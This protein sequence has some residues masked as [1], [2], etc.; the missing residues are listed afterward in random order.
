MR[1]EN[2]TWTEKHPDNRLPSPGKKRRR[3]SRYVVHAD[4]FDKC[5]I[6][7]TILDF[8]VQ[9]K[10]VPAISKL[11]PIIKE[12][13][14]FP[15]GSKSL[16]RIVKRMGFMWRKCQSKRK[17]L[18][19]RADTVEWRSKYHV[20]MNQYREEGCSILSDEESWVNGNVTFRKCRQSDDVM[21]IQAN[22]NSG[23]RFEVGLHLDTCI[24]TC[25][26]YMSIDKS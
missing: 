19:D 25:M 22:V 6:R 2:K 18:I 8:Y 12:K 11:L 10:R 24:R 4:D 9:E 13:I 26:R 23:N 20:K 17:I 14:H 7:N 15:W 5:A 1:Q 21:G 3:I 16:G